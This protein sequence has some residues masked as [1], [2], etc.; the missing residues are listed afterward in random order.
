MSCPIVILLQSIGDITWPCLQFSMQI[1]IL[2]SFCAY[3]PVPMRVVA[4]LLGQNPDVNSPAMQGVRDCVLFQTIYSNIKMEGES[5]EVVSLHQTTWQ[6]LRDKLLITVTDHGMY[7]NGFLLSGVLKCTL[8]TA[9]K[10]CSAAQEPGRTAAPFSDACDVSSIFQDIAAAIVAQYPH[11]HQD[12]YTNVQYFENYLQPHLE[13]LAHFRVGLGSMCNKLQMSC[14]KSD[15]MNTAVNTFVFA[16]RNVRL[17]SPLAQY[18]NSTCTLTLDGTTGVV[19][20][21]QKP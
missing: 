5:V 11:L 12:V 3:T 2:M 7:Y 19:G 20:S 17:A 21:Q 4:H 10:P 9:C 8:V 6:L 18:R 14:R 15:Y 16:C 13:S 1:F